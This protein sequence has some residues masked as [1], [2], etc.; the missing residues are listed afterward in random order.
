MESSSLRI[1]QMCC[2]T[3]EGLIRGKL[4]HL[5]E[6]HAMQFNLLNR[7]LLVEH[8]AGAAPRVI[9]AIASLGM[10]AQPLAAETRVRIEQMDC[11]TEE[12]LITDKLAREPGIEGCSST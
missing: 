11:P 9:A 6:V 4:Q 3:E 8:Q 2:P 1:E 5:A 7:T 12:R 10:Q